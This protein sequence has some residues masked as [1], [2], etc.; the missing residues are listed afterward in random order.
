[1][2]ITQKIR[3]YENLHIVF[4]LMKDSCWMLELKIPGAIMIVPTII[5]AVH[6]M[7][8]TRGTS[9]FY[10]NAAILCWIAANSFW[11]F[12]EFFNEDHLRGYSAIPF[13]LGFLFVGLY[14][15]RGYRGKAKDEGEGLANE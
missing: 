1:M 15:L 5:L 6:I 14:Y 3:Q 12:V 13:A 7:I 10:I 8:K 11:M 2:H 4:W 9:E